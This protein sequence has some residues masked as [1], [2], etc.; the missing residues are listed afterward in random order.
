M[1]LNPKLPEKHMPNIQWDKQ[2]TK[3]MLGKNFDEMDYEDR[4]QAVLT[5]SA[6]DLLNTQWPAP[7][8]RKPSLN[9][10]LVNMGR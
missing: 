7:D 10:C 5:L 9:P 6:D 2:K 1:L 4:V 3:D 8:I